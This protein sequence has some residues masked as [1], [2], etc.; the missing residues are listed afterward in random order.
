MSTDGNI[1]PLHIYKKLFPKIT[2][3]Q[4]AATKNSNVQLKMYNKTTITQLGT[5][6]VEVEHKNNKKKCRF[7]CS[8]QQW[9]DIARHA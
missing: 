9:A 6:I 8:S 5:C 3:E 2:Y 1:M 4:L 7:F